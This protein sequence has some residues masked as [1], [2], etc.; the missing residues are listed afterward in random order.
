MGSD[1]F[2]HQKYF[3]PAF[4]GS[5]HVPTVVKT[6]VTAGGMSKLNLQFPKKADQ[7]TTDSLGY[8]PGTGVSHSQQTTREMFVKN[9]GEWTGR[10]DIS[11]E[12][13][14]R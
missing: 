1:I 14:L 6:N 3:R 8:I 2:E 7:V 9:A 10:V 11:M 12:E 5:N 13:L 4:G